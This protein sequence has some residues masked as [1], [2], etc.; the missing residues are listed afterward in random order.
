MIGRRGSHDLVFGPIT[1]ASN[2]ETEITRCTVSVS[3]YISAVSRP[4]LD[5]ASRVVAI[6]RDLR[7]LAALA[8]EAGV[9]PVVRAVSLAAENLAGIKRRDG[10]SPPDPPGKPPS[11]Q[12]L[13]ARRSAARRTAASG[14]PRFE[15][16]GEDL[17]K[18]GW[19]RSEK[20]EYR[21][22]APATAIGLVS[23]AISRAATESGG[24]FRMEDL[25]PIADPSSGAELPAYQ[26]YIVVRWLR[27]DGLVES[28]GRSRYIV[29]DSAG[30][31]AAAAR[32]WDEINRKESAP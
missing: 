5:I 14:Y 30:L 6:E 31:P 29:P 24:T 11:G 16:Q 3:W 32:R 10:A 12:R 21:H 19:S 25:L 13:T 27:E 8:A 28:S 7:Q 22:R 18:I 2:R 23:D 15:V 20:A 9:W 4:S 1:A 26:A 17:V